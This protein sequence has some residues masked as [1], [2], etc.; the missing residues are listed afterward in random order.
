MNKN[1]F[2]GLYVIVVLLLQTACIPT[3]P[4]KNTPPTA[5]TTGVMIICEGSFNNGNGSLSWYDNTAKTLQ[6]DVFKTANNYALGDVVQSFYFYGNKLYLV[7]NNSGKIVAL[8]PTTFKAVSTI[9]NL[10]S[11]RYFLPLGA[12]KAWVTNFTLSG[13]TV[14]NEVDLSNNAVTHI[15]PTNWCE[16]LVQAA[17]GSVWTGV[18]RTNMLLRLDPAT[19][20]IT[21]TLRLSDSPQDLQLDKNGKLWVACTGGFV[22]DIPTL[23]C[24]NIATRRVEQTFSW[25]AGSG[26]A[27]FLR[28]NTNRDTLYYINAQKV[29]RL[30]I[31]ATALPT[32]PVIS[33]NWQYAYGLGIEPYNSSIWVADAKDFTQRGEVLR[34]QNN[35]TFINVL[36]VGIAPNGFWFR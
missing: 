4:I 13:N 23:S 19:R 24:V 36:T 27:N 16:Q 7:V 8:D 15:I 1:L 9:N 10:T 32:A 21:D 22:G 2:F 30:P 34:Y 31:T 6:N 33:G 5:N 26:G 11:P 29:W 14:I 17:D 25:A 28:T 20:R 3:E 35:G 12:N 18:M